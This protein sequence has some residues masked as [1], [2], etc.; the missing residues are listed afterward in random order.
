MRTL[1]SKSAIG[2]SLIGLITHLATPAICSSQETPAAQTEAAYG[3]VSVSDGHVTLIESD[4]GESV[5]VE[6]AEAVLAGDELRLAGGARAEVRLADRNL[7]R[8]GNEAEVAFLALAASADRNDLSTAL[9]LRRGTM[10]I[11][12]AD[13]FRGQVPPA[14]ETANAYI[15]L[16]G[17]GVYLVD[18]QGPE[19]TLIVVRRGGARLRGPDGYTALGA[20]EEAVVEGHDGAGVR[21]ASARGL[22]PV[23]RWG[24]EL[25]ADHATPAEVYVD[26][27][28]SYASASLNT[29]G[30]WVYVRGTRAWRPR[31]AHGWRPYW[32]GRWR[33]TPTGLLWV[34][35]EP[36]GW[37]PHHYGSWDLIPG[38]GW[39]W[40]PG[41]RFA[42]AWVFWYWGPKYVGWVPWGYYSHH[43][44]SRFRLSFAVYGSAGGLTVGFGDWCFTPVHRFG[45]RHQHRHLRTGRGL[46]RERNRLERGIITTDTYGI[47]PGH[48]KSPDRVKRVL[49][50]DASGRARDCLGE[51][52]PFVN[53]ERDGRIPDGWKPPVDGRS[54]DRTRALIDPRLPTRMVE[55]RSEPTTR[56]KA[57]Q[58]L[59]RR[60]SIDPRLP[61][62][63]VSRSRSTAKPARAGPEINRTTSRSKTVG[64]KVPKADRSRSTTRPKTTRSVST[65][66][67]TTG[68][69][70]TQS[71]TARPDTGKRPKT[72]G[73]SRAKRE[74]PSN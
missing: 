39:V 28:L 58:E 35:Y 52:D 10:Q 66:R 60:P 46:G 27:P 31:V 40:F 36:W 62:R 69:R 5:P 30:N 26:R 15:E 47:T 74:G 1:R 49:T 41:H 21:L 65:G 68:P 23:E 37:V 3:H 55:N 42:S 44:G 4:T 43:Y 13:D 53:R 11:V 57:R 73:R 45:H 71:K 72:T 48:W 19:R 25:A 8:L 14:I 7:I 33:H 67:R 51:V 32:K 24:E 16:R 63:M 17:P 61:T 9:R 59:A 54:K 2:A 56:E 50:V 64:V 70:A 29:Y 20:G 18:A 6:G 12:V 38:H 34:S 22:A